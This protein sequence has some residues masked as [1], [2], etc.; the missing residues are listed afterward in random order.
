MKIIPVIDLL[1]GQ[2]VHAKRGDRQNYLP[3]Q[4]S[5][6]GSSKP[7]DV[8]H[9]LLELYPFDTVYI[10]DI[11]A[12]QNNGDHFELVTALK[13][14]HHGIDIWLDAGFDSVSK[15]ELAKAFI[16]VLGTESISDISHYQAL[17]EAC[18]Q[19]PIL[20]L[21]FKAGVFQG[22][23][24]LIEN[25]AF[26][27]ENVIVMTLNK[28]G[29]DA[30]PDMAQLD[31]IQKIAMNNNIYAAGGV[32]GFADLQQLKGMH[33]HSVLVASALHAGL[34]THAQ[35]SEIVSSAQN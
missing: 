28:V 3:I 13:K 8:L 22:P 24:Q 16:S 9:A 18:G 23:E 14:R 5:L 30:G 34:I 33:I 15:I 11:N 1:N 12:I 2:V 26:W 27:P 17:K 32:R 6:C 31:A 4:S 10:A 19:Q 7:E 29:S 21:D 25:A 20:S 35:I